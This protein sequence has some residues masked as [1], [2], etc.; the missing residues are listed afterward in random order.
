MR[1]LSDWMPDAINRPELLRQ[2]RARR[3]LRSWEE[4]VG[5]ILA[6]KTT[7]DGFDRGTLWVAAAGSTWAQEVRLRKDQILGRLNELAHSSDLFQQM[8]V[9]T[10]EPNPRWSETSENP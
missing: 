9:G 10:R 8:R 2:A 4:V 7:P 5:P 3:A 6:Q 1:R